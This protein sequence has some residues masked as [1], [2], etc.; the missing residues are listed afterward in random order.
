MC[1]I[2][3]SILI[4][5]RRHLDTVI[6]NICFVNGGIELGIVVVEGFGVRRARDSPGRNQRGIIPAQLR[7]CERTSYPGQVTDST[8]SL[9][10]GGRVF[11]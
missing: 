5:E 9:E 2:E 10:L 1:D 11:N 8:Q 4:K 3:N 7:D 6:S